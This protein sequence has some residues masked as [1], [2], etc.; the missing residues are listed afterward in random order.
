MSR[1]LSSPGKRAG[2]LPN[3]HADIGGL[4]SSTR[5]WSLTPLETATAG[6]RM[7]SPATSDTFQMGV[8]QACHQSYYNHMI[9]AMQLIDHLLDRSI[10][11]PT[12]HPFSDTCQDKKK[13]TKKRR[14]GQKNQK[15]KGKDKREDANMAPPLLELPPTSA[16]QD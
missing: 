3:S 16:Q 7:L 6:A 11:A 5:C 10:I 4:L 9:E 12:R 8:L 15:E 1:L 2:H 13:K 14:G